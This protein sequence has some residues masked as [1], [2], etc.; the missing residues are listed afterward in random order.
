MHRFARLPAALLAPAL[1]LAG[2]VSASEQRSY[3]VREVSD[4]LAAFDGRTVFVHGYANGCE[5]SNTCTLT[6]GP[7]GTFGEAELPLAYDPEIRAMM[8]KAD[9][10]KV[11][12]EAKV[13]AIDDNVIYVGTWPVLT[14]T[15]L[16][17]AY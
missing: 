6:Q 8:L 12:I 14:A 1:L 5:Y 2:C 11:L 16:I 15:R 13:S 17:R 7:Q 10:Y 4:N 3:S 9:G